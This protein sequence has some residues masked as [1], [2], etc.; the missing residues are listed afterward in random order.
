[1]AKATA[2]VASVKKAA[3]SAKVGCLVAAGS[4]STMVTAC[5][6]VET[7]AKAAADTA[8][9][10]A[11]TAANSAF[12]AMKK[13]EDDKLEALNTA[14]A[15]KYAAACPSVTACPAIPDPPAPPA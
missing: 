14:S 15:A 4:N 1:M 3:E 8:K 10:A 6:A 2:D 11:D 5:G 9:T 12:T 7:A 13:Q